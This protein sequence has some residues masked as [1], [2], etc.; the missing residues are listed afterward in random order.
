MVNAARS[1]LVSVYSGQYQF[2]HQFLGMSTYYGRE[3]SG[4]ALSKDVESE[5]IEE[6]YRQ[7][8]MAVMKLESEEYVSPLKQSHKTMLLSFFGEKDFVKL[9]KMAKDGKINL[10][11]T[12]LG[13][14]LS[15]DFCSLGSVDNIVNCGTCHEALAKRSN[16][17]RIEQFLVAVERQLDGVSCGSPRFES[18]R[19]QREMAMNII[20]A[21]NV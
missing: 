14:C 17:P 5:L 21:L 20:E 15:K 1:K 12:L 9:L 13:V 3:F 4:L 6:V 10:R 19:K 7:L 18:L 8:A 2:K 11:E 16:K